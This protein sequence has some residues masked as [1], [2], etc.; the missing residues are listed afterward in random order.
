MTWK[1]IF[2]QQRIKKIITKAISDN[3]VA[4]SYCFYGIEGIGKEAVAI[5]FAKVMNCKNTFIE[6][7]MIYAC[8]VCSDCKL[9]SSFQH[10]NITYIHSIPAGTGKSDS[11][12]P[13]TKLSEEQIDSLKENY[14]QKTNNPYHK[15]E[16]KN[17]NQIKIGTIRDLKKNLSFSS[18]S[19]GRRFVII[20]KADELTQESA[21]AFLKTLEE[22]HPNVTIILTTNRK[23]NILQTILSRCQKIKFDNLSNDH[24]TQALMTYNH[25]DEITAKLISGLAEGSYTKALEFVDEGILAKRNMVVDILRISFKKKIYRVDLMEMIEEISKAKDKKEVENFILLLL[26]WLRDVESYRLLY[27]EKAIINQ[28]QK[29]TIMKFATSYGMKDIRKSIKECESTINLIRRNVAINLALLS[30]F[31][32]LRKIF[33]EN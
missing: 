21:N 5:E 10:P 1:K 32:K 4:H 25:L 8:D 17:A 14:E 26:V 23:D 7:E 6:N 3:R 30:L 24:I 13:I 12:N 33:I 28:D 19:E 16:L 29:E 31:L 20:S 9:I 27:K 11:D 22:P 2:G 15:I 18:N